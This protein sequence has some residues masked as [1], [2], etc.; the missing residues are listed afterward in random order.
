VAGVLIAVTWATGGLRAQ[1]AAPNQVGPGATIDQGR[2]SVKVIGAQTGSAK[3]GFEDTARPVLVVRMRV[4]NTGKDTVGMS[5][6]SFDQ[7]VLLRPAPPYRFP[8]S[9]RNDPAK[10]NADS[11][12]PRVPRDIDVIW[13]LSGPAPRQ[14]TLDLREW[15][16]HLQFDHDAYYWIA[17]KTAATVALVTVPVRQGGAA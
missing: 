12:P 3:V 16:R 9:V 17:G 10:G 13:K 7:G 11:L 5:G 1:T 2:F 4:T 8:D 6:I 14:V 15:T